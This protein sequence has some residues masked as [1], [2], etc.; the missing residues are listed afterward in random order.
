MEDFY[1]PIEDKENT[2][3]AKKAEEKKGGDKA[4]GKPK[5]NELDKFLDDHNKSGPSDLILKLQ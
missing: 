3:P 4:G 1:E 5:K 2:K